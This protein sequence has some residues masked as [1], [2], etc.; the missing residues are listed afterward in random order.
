MAAAEGI[1]EV[2]QQRLLGG[3]HIGLQAVNDKHHCFEGPAAKQRAWVG[4]A[5]SRTVHAQAPDIR[6][7]LAAA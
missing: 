1:Q 5:G 2:V 4:E 6:V 7:S 3:T